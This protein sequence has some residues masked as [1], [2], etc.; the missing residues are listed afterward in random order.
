MM[1]TLLK[2]ACFL[3]F[4]VPGL[5]PARAAGGEQTNTVQ[6][7]TLRNASGC[8]ARITNYGG[9]ILSL[10][11]PDRNGN[12]DDVVLGFDK[13]EDYRAP[14]YLKGNAYFGALIGRYANRIARGHFTLDGKSYQIP[15]NDGPNS[16]HG[17]QAGFDQKV[18]QAQEHPGPV[19]SLELDYVSRD[20][21]EGFPGNL[22]VKAVYT[23]VDTAL[24]I[25]FTATTDQPTVLNLTN[26]AYFNLKGAGNGDVLDHEIQIEADAFTPVDAKSI[27]LPGG[28]VGV[29]G[30]PFDFTRPAK[31]GARIGDADEQIKNGSGYDHNFIVRSWTS[32]GAVRRLATVTEPT[33]GRVLEV[34]G[35]QPAVQ[36]YSG[37]FLDGTLI[38]KGGKPYPKRGAFCL[39]PQHFPDSPNRPDFPSVVL[40]PG[41][42]YRHT[43]VYR[44]LVAK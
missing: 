2:T 42:T 8:E 39:E 20:G 29:I 3:A 24:Q 38:G 44:F 14:A 25:E 6:I 30:T 32:G 35:D 4:V 10:L 40:R 34:D 15:T 23:L 33:T 28:P 19:P 13:P 5:N 16:L 21:E 41:E 22:S 36:F 43:M 12:F 27:P 9:I 1:S 11:V 31:I 17:G 26:H 7:Y 37:N 18:W